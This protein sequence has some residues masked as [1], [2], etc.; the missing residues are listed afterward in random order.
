MGR[1]PYFSSVTVPD[2]L[3]EVFSKIED[4]LQQEHDTD[5]SHR[6]V[7]ESEAG[8]MSSADKLLLQKLS[9]SV[10]TSSTTIGGGSGGG[11]TIVIQESSLARTFLFMGA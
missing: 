4:I 8:F 7:T 11:S 2:D 5:G 10:P 9:K 3:H 6:L 1:L